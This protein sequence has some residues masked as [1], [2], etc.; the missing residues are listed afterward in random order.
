MTIITIGRGQ[1]NK[2]VIDEPEI[3]RLHA[4]VKV[5]NTGKL[6]VIDKSSNGTFVN[7]IR[8]AS[9]VAVPVTRK[10]D[11]S[12]ASVRHLD[13]TEIPDPA[14]KI[15]IGIIAALAA[16]VLMVAAIFVIPMLDS[17][18][19][20]PPEQPI[21]NP[22]AVSNDSVQKKDTVKVK[23]KD[24]KN[25]TTKKATNANWANEIVAREAAQKRAAAAKNKTK[26]QPKPQSATTPNNNPNHNPN[27]NPNS[28]SKPKPTPKPKPKPTGEGN[29]IF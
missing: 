29:R 15:K 8:I 5:N 27:H 19:E 26:T 13:W 7:G 3:S 28:N 24:E 9:N 6:W 10:D 11:V 4:I 17:S 14:K 2:Y 23:D 20:L 18:S 22:P 1:E 16:I 25:D 21:S 12:F